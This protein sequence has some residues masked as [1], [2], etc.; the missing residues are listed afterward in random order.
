MYLRQPRCRFGGMSGVV[1]IDSALAHQTDSMRVAQIC[2]QGNDRITAAV[3]QC[4][5]W[6]KG[7]YR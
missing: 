7:C 1:L 5:I 4:P 2:R 6:G 3:I